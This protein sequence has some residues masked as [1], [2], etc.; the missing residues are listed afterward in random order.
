MSTTHIDAI[1]TPRLIAI[2]VLGAIG[3]FLFFL[4]TAAEMIGLVFIFLALLLLLG[5]FLP[6]LAAVLFCLAVLAVTALE[7]PI[8]KAAVTTAPTGC[9]VVVIL[10]AQV[11]GEEPSP[12]LN[13][14]IQAG[15]DY[16]IANNSTLAVGSGA[17]GDDEIMTEAQCIEN[18]LLEIGVDPNRIFK[19]ENS[20]STW[21]NVSFSLALVDDG[22]AL[23]SDGSRTLAEALEA[24]GVTA[25]DAKIAIVSSEYHCYRIQY[26]AKQAGRQVYVIAAST[27]DPISKINYFLREIPAMIKA[28]LTT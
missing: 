25:S 4:V 22:T 11:D 13:D 15:A 18:E 23:S 21:E 5:A 17:Q 19:E 16:L 20:A 6:K 14:R 26:L 12:S 9:D 28:R 8:L 1:S 27:S 7:L 24:R 3:I 10:G 2:G